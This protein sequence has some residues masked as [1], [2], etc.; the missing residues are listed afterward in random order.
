MHLI[1]IILIANKLCWLF[2]STDFQN[3]IVQRYFANYE[4]I[5]MI[6]FLASEVPI[7]GYRICH[8]LKKN[9]KAKNMSANSYHIYLYSSVQAHWIEA[10]VFGYIIYVQK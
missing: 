1:Y 4:L 7:T 3:S 9:A 6:L 10:I 2:F 8:L 5:F